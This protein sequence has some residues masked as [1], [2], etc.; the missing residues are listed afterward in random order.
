MFC[1]SSTIERASRAAIVPI[2]TL[3]WL[4]HS[5]D[6]EWIVAGLQSFI[7]SAVIAE[8][9][10][11]MPLKPWCRP[12]SR[13]VRFEARDQVRRQPGVE[14]LVDDKLELS[15]DEVAEV[16]ERDLERV[17]R[18]ADVAAV[19]VAAALDA[20]AADVEQRVVVGRVDL[21][22]DPPCTQAS[23]SRS[24]PITCGA[25]RIEY[26]SCTWRSS[27]RN[28]APSRPPANSSSLSSESS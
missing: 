6:R 9:H 25:Q 11:C 5:V 7:A 21:D 20:A 19:E 17:H 26:L 8:Q 28:S 27:S 13:V 2:E 14:L 16:G 24:T 23:T 1:V 12:A 10:S 15:V 3:S 22:R 4:W 18:L